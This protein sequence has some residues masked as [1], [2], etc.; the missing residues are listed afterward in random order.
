MIVFE[1]SK[2][3]DT[4]GYADLLEMHFQG[5][6]VQWIVLYSVAINS[7]CIRV[8]SYVC[9]SCR[10]TSE[11]TCSKWW[12]LSS[13][14]DWEGNNCEVLPHHML[15]FSWLQLD[16]GVPKKFSFPMA[17]QL[18]GVHVAKVCTIFVGYVLWCLKI[19]NQNVIFSWQVQR[20]IFILA[21][22]GVVRSLIIVPLC[23]QFCVSEVDAASSGGWCRL[24]GEPGEASSHLPPL[25][26]CHVTFFL[27]LS[28]Y[29]VNL[30]IFC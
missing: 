7:R 30:W 26:V 9:F 15:A 4:L 3:E 13:L 14:L 25:H 1:H 10:C 29:H 24:V 12:S 5:M 18:Q 22:Y 23:R 6:S 21:S 8:Y 17:R 20:E 2:S 27:L 11:E 19:Q 16:E 28:W